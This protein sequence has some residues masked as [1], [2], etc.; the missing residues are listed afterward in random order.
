MTGPDYV[1]AS[2]RPAVE[3]IT[4]MG[5]A[6]TPWYLATG[7]M[8]Q[9]RPIMEPASKIKSGSHS[10]LWMRAV[11][12]A[13]LHRIL[14]AVG[15]APGGLRANEINDLVLERKVLLTPANPHPKPTTLYHYRT[16]LLR[17]NALIREDRKLIANTANPDVG[18]LLREP[19]PPNGEQA[20]S[21]AAREHFATLVLS[22]EDCRRLFFDLF[23]SSSRSCT[24]VSDFRETAVP[25]SWIRR[26]GPLG[27]E[28]VLENTASGRSARLASSVGVSSI[29]YGVR[30]W[31]RDE[32]K[33]ID[34]YSRPAADATIMF[35]VLRHNSTPSE[36]RESLAMQAV[37]FL[38]DRRTAEEWTLYSISDLIID[39]CQAHRQPRSSLFGAIDWLRRE[40]PFHTVLIPTSRAMA[41][42]AVTSPQ[43][44]DLALRRYY[45]SP[46]GPYISH[47]R[48]HED[49]TCDTTDTTHRHVQHASEARA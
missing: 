43:R 1:A 7:R 47:I 23:M 26:H 33:L 41:T 11:S 3:T 21:D 44:E 19:A 12:F 20:L 38:L 40:W 42:F 48:V 13:G 5:C 29:L 9:H 36:G 25:V 39:Y 10:R 16:T 28:V 2:V 22:T 49:V 15:D 30:Y 46:Q 6:P 31:A 32:L 14:K 27:A 35:P 37:R 24:S 45:K 8:N 4:A 34:E 17:L 18:A